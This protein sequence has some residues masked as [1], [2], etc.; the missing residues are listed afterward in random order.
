MELPKNMKENRFK[1]EICEKSFKTQNTFMNHFNIVHDNKGKVITCNI[2]TRNFQSQI[3][4]NIHI[5]TVHL[6]HKNYK[7]ESCDKSFSQA[8]SLKRHIL[9]VHED[10]STNAKYVQM[11]P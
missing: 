10:H 9:T 7:C 5:K 6:S 11:R 4:L 1:C 8:G 2:C 3:N